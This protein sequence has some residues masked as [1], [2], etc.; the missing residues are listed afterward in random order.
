MTNILAI[1]VV[2]AILVFGY[3]TLKEL[4]ICIM[5]KYFGK[6]YKHVGEK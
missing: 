6:N 4:T 3:L 2:L 1:F 5:N